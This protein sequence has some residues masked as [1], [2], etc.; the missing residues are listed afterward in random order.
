MITA[1]LAAILLAI[2]CLFAFCYLIFRKIQGIINQIIAFVSPQEE[3]KPSPLANFIEASSVIAS[4][5]LANEAKAMIM[6]AQSVISHNA[7]TAAVAG[8]E[9]MA[10]NASPW[11]GVLLQMLPKKLKTQLGSNGQLIDMALSR[12]NSQSTA[13]QSG[14]NGSH[15]KFKL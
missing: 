11:L 4:K 2:I 7:H 3:G 15:P 14:N 6:Q 1:L 10:T 12:T 13:V 9:Q 5:T 8:V